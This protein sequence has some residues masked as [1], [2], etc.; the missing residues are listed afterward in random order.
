MSRTL[1]VVKELI[2]SA[3]L[4]YASLIAALTVRFLWIDFQGIIRVS[5]KLLGVCSLF[6]SCLPQRSN[7]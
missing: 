3:I 2:G 4:I 1:S 5:G 7:P 6:H